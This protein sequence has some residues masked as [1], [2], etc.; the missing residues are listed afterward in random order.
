MAGVLVLNVTYEPIGVVSLRRSIGLWL[1]EKVDVLEQAEATM[2]SAS[3]SMRAPSV[4]RL[5]YYV[6]VPHH[7]VAPLSRKAV[8]ARDGGRCQYCGAPADTIDH[9]LAKSRG[10]THTW[11]NVVAACRTCNSRKGNCLLAETTL[12]LRSRPAPPRRHTWVA[13]ATG[14]PI[15]DEWNSYLERF[16]RKAA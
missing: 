4:I 8:F 7:R 15:P 5:R 2:R 10:G 11:D 6:K 9:V 16:D 13:A 14:R 1:S 3:L 12:T